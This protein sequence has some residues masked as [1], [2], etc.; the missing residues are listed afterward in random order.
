MT[1]DPSPVRVLVGS[2]HVTRGGR[3]RR[4]REGGG[5]RGRKDGKGEGRRGSGGGRWRKDETH[6]LTMDAE[7]KNRLLAVECSTC[8]NQITSRLP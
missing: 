6:M 2:G 4:E 8:L 7:W 5:G 3:G 1:P